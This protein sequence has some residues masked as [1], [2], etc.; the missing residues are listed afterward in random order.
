MVCRVML[1]RHYTATMENF[2]V[3]GIS[4]MRKYYTQFDHKNKRLQFACAK[5]YRDDGTSCVLR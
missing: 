2:W 5:M 4:F 1:K 3:F